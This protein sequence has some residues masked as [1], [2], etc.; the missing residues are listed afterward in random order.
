ML[1]FVRRNQTFHFQSCAY[2][3]VLWRGEDLRDLLP[4]LGCLLAVASMGTTLA[5]L[6][7]SLRPGPR[8]IQHGDIDDR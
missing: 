4:E 7:S 2:H 1:T 3:E 5:V 6:V 8:D